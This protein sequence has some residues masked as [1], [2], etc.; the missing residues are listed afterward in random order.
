MSLNKLAFN[1]SSSL[2]T[3]WSS[4]D[5]SES[6]DVHSS[7]EQVLVIFEWVELHVVMLMW[8]T[9]VFLKSSVGVSNSQV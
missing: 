3:S 5:A 6:I 4:M 7:L 1:Q 9:M 2:D 8:W